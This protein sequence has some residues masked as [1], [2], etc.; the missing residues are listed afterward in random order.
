MNFKPFHQSLYE[1]ILALGQDYSSFSHSEP[2]ELDQSLIG[3]PNTNHHLF[4]HPSKEF[5]IKELEDEIIRMQV[6][7]NKSM[8]K[9]KKEKV[10]EGR[11]DT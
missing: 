9:G 6:E 2:L 10:K 3:S 8:N 11:M 1:E 7:V 5:T 4:S